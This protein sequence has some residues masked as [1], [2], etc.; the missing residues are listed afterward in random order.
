MTC[1]KRSTRMSSFTLHRARARY[2]TDVV[3]REIDE[4][5]VLRALLLRRAKLGLVR[6]VLRIVPAARSRSGDRVHDDL[7]AL[8]AH[9]GLRRRADKRGRGCLEQEHVRRRIHVTQRAVQRERIRRGRDIEALREDDL[10]AVAFGDELARARDARHVFL[11]RAVRTD[12]DRAARARRGER[13]Q[14][15]VERGEHAIDPARGVTRRGCVVVREHGERVAQVIERDDGV[16]DAE[17]GLGQ[18]PRSVRIVG[19][20]RQPFESARGFVA[21]EPDGAAAEARQARRAARR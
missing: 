12:L 1:E 13:R 21:D 8:H 10:D 19:R 5:H 2:A 20:E 18:A 9:E 16:V 7:P 15:R 14:R 4:H 11:G 6:R 3:A 17:D